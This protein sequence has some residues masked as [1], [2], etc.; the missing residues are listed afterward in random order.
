MPIRKKRAFATDLAPSRQYVLHHLCLQ[1]LYWR[2][3]IFGLS[4]INFQILFITAK[5]AGVCIQCTRPFLS[6]TNRCMELALTIFLNLVDCKGLFL[7]KNFFHGFKILVVLGFMNF[8]GQQLLISLVN[9]D[10]VCHL[11]QFLGM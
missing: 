1:L 3:C 9:S 4:S 11:R 8:Y 6:R 7:N 5:A 10:W 2:F